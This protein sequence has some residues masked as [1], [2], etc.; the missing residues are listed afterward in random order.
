MLPD[1]NFTANP[2]HHDFISLYLISDQN[3]L[4]STDL[5]KASMNHEF[6]CTIIVLSDFLNYH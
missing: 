4:S 1:F 6:N 2:Y 3:I 5:F